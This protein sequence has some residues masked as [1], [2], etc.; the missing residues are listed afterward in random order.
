MTVIGALVEVF[1][2]SVILI[3]CIEETAAIFLF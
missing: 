3:Q 1:A 2:I